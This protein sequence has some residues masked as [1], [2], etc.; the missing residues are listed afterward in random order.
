[1]NL[2][3]LSLPKFTSAKD[4]EAFCLALYQKVWADSN[5]QLH[6]ASGQSQQGVDIFGRHATTGESYG[7]QCKVRSE[8]RLT[9]S[10]IEA[11]VERA[12][13]F[14]PKLRHLVVAT[15]ANRDGALQ[16]KV[17]LLSEKRRAAGLFSVHVVAWE[18]LIETLSEFPEVA[19]RFY[20]FLTVPRTDDGAV[21]SMHERSDHGSAIAHRLSH[22]LALLN[23]TRTYDAISVS[24]VAEALDA[25]RVSDVSKYFEG[26]DEPPIRFLRA[27]AEKF[28][29]NPEWLIH[30][31]D[32]AF[33]CYE[34]VLFS[35]LDAIPYLEANSPEEIIVVRSKSNCGECAIVARLDEWRYVTVGGI[36]HVSSH[37]G[38]TGRS[39]LLDLCQLFV[40]MLTNRMPCRGYAVDEETFYKLKDGEVY[41][42]SVFSGHNGNADWWISLLDIDHRA[43]GAPHYKEWH[44][45]AFMDAQEIL[46]EH[47]TSEMKKRFL[48]AR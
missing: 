29:A 2:R 42:G 26:Q 39:Q 34:P 16:T 35:P 18:D 41:P 28:G 17:R 36:W 22:A 38:A 14:Q 9:F 6:A 27:F 7:V 30:G 45:Q 13:E 48:S 37:V 46:R 1:M 11:D 12:E 8:R 15:T 3:N 19:Q 44:G 25:E 40:H 32:E 31:A 23:E 33:Y 20:S 47:A 24:H 4:F 5:A 21:G 43:P 10:D